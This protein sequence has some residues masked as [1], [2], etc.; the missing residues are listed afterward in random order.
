MSLLNRSYEVGF[1]FAWPCFAYALLRKVQSITR[2]LARL[3]VVL[4]GPAIDP[5]ASVSETPL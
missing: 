3:I 1:G 2:T 4:A 5:S